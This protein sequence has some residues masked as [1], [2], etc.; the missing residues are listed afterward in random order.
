M[1][2]FQKHA[3]VIVVVPVLLK[4]ALPSKDFLH[5]V[6]SNFFLL[7]AR[8]PINESSMTNDSTY[9][10]RRDGYAHQV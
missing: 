6:P 5:E 2:K 3:D 9:I 8:I 1:G 4:S 7:E 10:C